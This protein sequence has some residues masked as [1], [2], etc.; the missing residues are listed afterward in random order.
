MTPGKTL[1]VNADDLGFVPSVTRGIVEAVE[2]GIVTSASLMVN[3]PATAHAI[4]ELA[5]LRDRGFSPS[6]GLHFNIVVGESLTGPSSLTD[7]RTRRF[8]PLST[9]IWRSWRGRLPERDARAE[10]EAQ[11]A[12]AQALLAPLGMRVTH[13]DSHRHTHCLPGLFELV[14]QAAKA[15]GIAHVRHPHER[16]PTLL[17]RPHALVA[18]AVL[19][20]MIGPRQSTDDVRF[21]GVALMRSRTFDRDVMDL[22][23]A[24][25]EGTTELMV[26]PGYDSPELAAIDGYR[27]PRERELR[28]LTSPRL[29]ESIREMGVRLAPFGST[30]PVE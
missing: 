11:L 10:L 5:A 6:I 18:T 26:H 27:A 29:R 3:M 1:V 23:R 24:L 16:G 7:S 4:G 17:G 14:L 19:R 2:T 21:A 20:R 28:A 30:A 22:V 12:R 25:P 15:H 13:I 8:H 9:H